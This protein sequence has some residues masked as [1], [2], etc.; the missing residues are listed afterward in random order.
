MLQ[1]FGQI[2]EP[3]IV[4]TIQ[5]KKPKKKN[6]NCLIDDISEQRSRQECGGVEDRGEAGP[7]A[8][9]PRLM[10]DNEGQNQ[11]MKIEQEKTNEQSSVDCGLPRGQDG[12]QPQIIITAVT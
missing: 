6:E 1:T 9:S 3:G 12:T 10:M 11:R 4:A 7:S 8:R 2:K 5:K